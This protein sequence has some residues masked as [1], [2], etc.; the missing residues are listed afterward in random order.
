MQRFLA[1]KVIKHIGLGIVLVSVVAFM[2]LMFSLLGA[3]SCAVVS[4]MFLGT[5]RQG[6]LRSILVS[7]VFPAV[8]LVMAHVSQALQER[9]NVQ[10]SLV[11]FGS[12]WIAYFVT[13]GLVLL[14]RKAPQ[15][16]CNRLAARVVAS[17]ESEL[18]RRSGTGLAGGAPFIE[19]ANDSGVAELRGRW[20]CTTIGSDGQSRTKVMELDDDRF[21]LRVTDCRGRL[22]SIAQGGLRLDQ[23]GLFWT[24]TI[25]LN[26]NSA[27]EEVGKAREKP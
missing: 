3:I 11:C 19:P 21:A 4:G 2:T 7:L 20:S 18:G 22:L 13:C 23:R 9:Q 1:S 25:S 15:P 26:L 27:V 6:M 16:S 12:Y 10:F 5:A 14:E 8:T 24:L 17:R